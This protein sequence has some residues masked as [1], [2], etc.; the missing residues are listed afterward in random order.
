MVLISLPPKEPLFCGDEK[1]NRPL[2][3]QR[4][5]VDCVDGSSV[6]VKTGANRDHP[7]EQGFVRQRSGACPSGRWTN[8]VKRFVPGIT[9][10]ALRALSCAPTTPHAHP[11]LKFQQLRLIN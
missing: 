11:A 3:A 1:Q 10:I 5:L 9:P 2:E 7:A 6:V 4:A 8:I